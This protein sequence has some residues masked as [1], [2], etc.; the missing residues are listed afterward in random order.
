MHQGKLAVE[1]SE[2]EYVL[3]NRTF[4]LKDDDIYTLINEFEIKCKHRSYDSHNERFID[5]DK[6]MDS[7]PYNRRGSQVGRYGKQKK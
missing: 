5:L 7:L 2:F 1:L 6:L 3:S 4:R